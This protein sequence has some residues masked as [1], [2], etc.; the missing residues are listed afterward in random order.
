MFITR[1]LESRKI[2]KLIFQLPGIFLSRYGSRVTYTYPQILRTIEDHKLDNKYTNY[3]IAIFLSKEE[4]SNHLDAKEIENIRTEISQRFLH[5]RP[6]E[7][8]FK[9]R[10][11]KIGNNGHDSLSGSGGGDS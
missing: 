11:T 1:Y 2:K 4:A 9:N 10:K 3:V 8:L 5:G 6:I 7:S